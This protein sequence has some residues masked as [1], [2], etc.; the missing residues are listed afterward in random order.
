VEYDVAFGLENH[1][2][3]HDKMKAIVI[4]SLDNVDMKDIE[5]ASSRIMTSGLSAK[6]P[7]IATRCF[8]PP[9]KECGSYSIYQTS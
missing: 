7:A 4:Q 1:A 5:V 2:V 9:D 8:W 3:S 6:T